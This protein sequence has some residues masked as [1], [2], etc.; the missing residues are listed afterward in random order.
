MMHGTYNVKKQQ[1]TLFY[2][3]DDFRE[4]NTGYQVCGLI[5]STTFLWDPSRSKKNWARY[6]QKFAQVFL[7]SAHYS[8]QILIKKPEFSREI[9]EVPKHNISW[10]S[11]PLT[12]ELFEADRQTDGQEWRS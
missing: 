4:K 6:Y 9:F 8:C 7:W 11:V 10:K 5:F 12:A 1:S 3:W 2:T